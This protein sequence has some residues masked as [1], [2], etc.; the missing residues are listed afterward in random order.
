M[1]PELVL[2]APIYAPTQRHLEAHY[3]VHRLWEASDQGA[4]LAE[5][6]DRIDTVVTPGGRGMNAAEMRA[7]PR[8]KLIA[9]FAVGVDAV[10]VAAATERGIKVTNT[11]DVL[12][13]DVADLALALILATIR[14]VAVGDRHV[15]SGAWLNG[16]MPLTQSLRGKTLGIVGMGRIG[17]AI[18]KR[19]EA[20]GLS[21]A[22]QG[23]H[24][25]HLAYPYHADPV[26]LATACDILVA[27][28]PGGDATRGIIGRAVIDALGPEGIFVNIAR[29]S[30][31]DEPA[32]VDALV[33]GRLGGAGLDVFVDEPRVPE[34]LLA[35]DQVVLQPHV[36]SA[37]HATR[38]AM[39]QLVI[40]NVAAWF[41]KQPLPTPVN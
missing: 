38:T 34:A 39:G 36:G 8:L 16:A 40:D 2:T 41:A 26:A 10:D 31:V 29:G 23:P 25:K 12:T 4:K 6:A 9:C 3:T 7:L 24:D 5:L 11:P 14:R 1:K 20:F 21:I 37:S 15:R 32:L 22:Y 33:E 30:V 28:C 17:Q 19:G 13:E 18:A 27:A 35:L